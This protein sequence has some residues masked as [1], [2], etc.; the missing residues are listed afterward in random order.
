MTQEAL[1]KLLT[2]FNGKPGFA[3]T[4]GCTEGLSIEETKQMLQALIDNKQIYSDPNLLAW[5]DALGLPLE[6]EPIVG[7]DK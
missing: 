4:D 5:A 7:G 3:G 1:D 2:R 6:K